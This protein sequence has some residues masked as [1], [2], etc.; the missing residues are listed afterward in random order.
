MPESN[1]DPIPCK[2]VLESAIAANLKNV[3]IIGMEENG[4]LYVAGSEA[5]LGVDMLLMERAKRHLLNLLEQG[6]EKED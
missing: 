5:D 6:L 4:A 2:V 3:L 1:Y